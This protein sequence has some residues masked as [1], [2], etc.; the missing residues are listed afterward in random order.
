MAFFSHNVFIH[1]SIFSLYVLKCSTSVNRCCDE[2]II[3]KVC[4]VNKTCCD[5]MP[6]VD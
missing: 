1:N 5:M 4:D 6:S 2:Y 3:C